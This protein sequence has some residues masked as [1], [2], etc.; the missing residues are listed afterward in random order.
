V[1]GDADLARLTAAE[2]VA[3][4]AGALAL[5]LFRARERLTIETKG[6]Q[7]LVSAADRAVEAQIRARLG[8][9]F[10]ADAVLGEEAGFAP[11]GAGTWVVDPIDGTW[12]FLNGIGSWCVSVAYVVDGRV[13][14]GVIADPCAG[15]LFAALRGHG[16]RLNGRPIRVSAARS[17][18]Q[19]SVSVGFSTR[20]DRGRTLAALE[21]LMAAG[22]VYHRHGSG[23]LALAWTAC[24][25]LIGYLETHM[26]SWDCLAG[27]LL[28][29]EAGGFASEFLAGD[30]LHAGNRVL[31]GPPQLRAALEALLPDG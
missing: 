3:Q 24:G 5:A 23:A 18:A 25:R 17:L 28:I 1:Q 22:G 15:E 13:E 19:G 4:E 7:D 2:A 26:M 12:C 29:E 27:L 14:L 31:A 30:A 16:A 10:P 20:A 21:R 6:P 11:G 9:L 8:A